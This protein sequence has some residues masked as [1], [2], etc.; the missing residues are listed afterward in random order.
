M[1][2]PTIFVSLDETREEIRGIIARI[3]ANENGLALARVNIYAT[4]AAENPRAAELVE[5][6]GARLN[7]AFRENFAMVDMTLAVILSETNAVETDFAA[8]NAATNKFLANFS[9]GAF[10]RVFLISDKNERGEVLPES[11]K[12]ISEIIAALPLLNETGSRFCEFLAAKAAASERPIFASAGFWQ[13]PPPK[14]EQNRDLHRLADAIESEFKSYAAEKIFSQNST[15]YRLTP[16][17]LAKNI[18]SVAAKQLRPWHLW[19]RTVKEAENL[20]FGDAA[21]KFFEKNYSR[22]NSSCEFES[23]KKT[24]REAACEERNF[25]RK[26][27]ETEKIICAARDEIEQIETAT[28][29]VKHGVDYVKTK[30]GEAYAARY[31]LEAARADYA[32]LSA[33]HAHLKAR[34]DYLRGA[35]R[36]LKALPT[37][38]PPQ[39]TPTD[40]HAPIA[41]SL[42]RDDGLIRESHIIPD[43]SGNPRLLRLIGGFT[44]ADLVRCYAP[45]RPKD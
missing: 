11:S 36:R 45:S 1:K 8:R 27:E 21:E 35:A 30:I 14:L 43:E 10:D 22:E 19:G 24:L 38:A 2:N 39:E 37:T 3:Q 29:R 44:S 26:I 6:A 5:T 18:A 41:I 16:V 15:G 7:S 13:N 33:E 40:A 32:N 31:E 42:L 4:V 28:C 17:E 9:P 23:T 20:L 25:L 34:L 12:K